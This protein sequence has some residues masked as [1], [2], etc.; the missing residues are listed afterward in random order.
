MFEN[1]N[2][3]VDLFNLVLLGL[4]VLLGMAVLTYDPADPPSTLVYP[5]LAAYQNACGPIGAYVAH[6]LLESVGIGA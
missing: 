5:P 4:T 3:R 1:R 6:F 2:L